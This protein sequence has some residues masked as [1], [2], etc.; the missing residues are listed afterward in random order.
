MISIRSI[1]TLIVMITCNMTSVEAQ[2]DFAT[3]KKNLNF[4]ATGLKH[5]LNV[6]KD[7][8]KLSSDKI[9]QR[10]Y[11]IGKHGRTIDLWVNK[12]QSDIPLRELTKGAYVFVVEQNYLKIVFQVVINRDHSLTEFNNFS[13]SSAARITTVVPG[14]KLQ[15]TNV[16][17]NEKVGK[18][19][20]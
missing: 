18:E 11:S 19:N 10:I 14:E 3:L 7:T 1:L 9:I 6:T 8:L 20:R 16:F 2:G 4:R 13:D 15:E 5:D 12:K 17:L